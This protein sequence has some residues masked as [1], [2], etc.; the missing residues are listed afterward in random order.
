MTSFTRQI[1]LSSPLLRSAAIAALLGTT[2]LM[3]P[4]HAARAGDAVNA[5]LQ[6]SQANPPQNQ[7]AA[8][9]AQNQGETVETRITS[10]HSQLKITSDEDANWNNVAQA[11][12]QNAAA[13]DELVASTHTTPPQNMTAVDDLTTYEKFAQAHVA[14]LKN[15]ISSFSTLYNAMPAGQQKLADQVFSN[16]GHNH[17]KSHS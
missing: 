10:L 3:S 8:A 15:L 13:M 6:L 17:A 16:F 11:M 7:T 9:P 14:G 1:A 2:M 4:L 5:P 12:R